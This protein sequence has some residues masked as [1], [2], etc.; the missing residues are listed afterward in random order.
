MGSAEIASEFHPARAYFSSIKKPLF[1]QAVFDADQRVIAE[2]VVVELL[3]AGTVVESEDEAVAAHL[4]RRKPA[5]TPVFSPP[6]R[7]HRRDG[8]VRGQDRLLEVLKRRVFRK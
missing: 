8:G 2:G 3:A 5:R 4:L 1:V 7:V 6:D